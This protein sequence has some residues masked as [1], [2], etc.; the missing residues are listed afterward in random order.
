[1]TGPVV[2]LRGV[3]KRFG[4]KTVVDGVELAVEPGEFLTLL[5]PSGCGKTT[6][7]RMIAGFE[8]PTE[9]R[10]RIA[11]EDVTD[12]P[13]QR[14]AVNTVFQNYALFPH[15]TVWENVAFGLRA[16]G[17]PAR[18]IRERVAEALEVVR[19][20]GL[21]RR[22][23]HQLSGGQQQ[24]VAI[25]RAVV[26]RPR[27]LLLDEPL[28]ALDQKLRREMQ[29][30]LKRLQRGLGIAFVFVT[31]DQEEALS[32]SDRVVVLREGRVEQ[33][34]TPREV[35]ENPANRFVA[36]F[37]G[38][39]NLLEA[40]IEEVGAAGV[41]GR[42]GT[43]RVPVVPGRPVAPGERVWIV[44]RPED[45]RVEEVGE[46]ATEGLLGRVA[47]RVYK[48]STLD[49]VI[50]LDAGPRILAK[51][52]FDEDDPSFDHVVGQRVRVRWVP[53]WEVVLPHGDD[54]EPL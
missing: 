18:E 30:E 38:E 21:E 26:N 34:G 52:F 6:I 49:S 53:G 39:A 54:A 43:V 22:R 19:L 4:P 8:R 50:D 23:P 45:V 7:L 15:L 29:V 42:I 16:R 24:R 40:R 5:G 9:G 48:G 41:W 10:V 3:T 36:G 12:L 2:E 47:E 13:P 14:R 20:T 11:G 44:V 51:E 35:Y 37:V 1:M 31:H 17:A 32:M 27:C 25:A 33:V 28:N 46:G